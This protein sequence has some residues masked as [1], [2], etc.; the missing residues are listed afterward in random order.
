M[1]NVGNYFLEYA[2]IFRNFLASQTIKVRQFFLLLEAL[3]LFSKVI[4][5]EC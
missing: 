4:A 1:Q 5:K 3:P 2:N